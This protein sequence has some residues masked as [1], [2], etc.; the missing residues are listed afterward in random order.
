[1]MRSLPDPLMALLSIFAPRFSTPVW[2]HVQVLRAGAILCQGPHPVAAVL[3]VMGLEGKHAFCKYH[4]VLSRARWSGWHGSKILFGRLVVLVR[5]AGVPLRI[6]I[7]ETLDRRQGKRIKAKGK[8]RDA[9]RSTPRVVVK[10]GR[11]KWIC[12]MVGVPLPWRN[13]RWALPFLSLLAPSERANQPAGKP[14]KT[15][16]EWAIR[17]VRIV[18]RWL[19]H[20][21]WTLVGDGAYA[22]VA[23]AQACTAQRVTL[24]SRLR[25]G[26]RRLD[27]PA[28]QPAGNRGRKPQKGQRRR[29]LSALAQAPTSPWQETEMAWYRGEPRRQQWLSG[30][31][32]WHPNG[33]VPVPIRWVLVVDPAGHHPPEAFFSTAVTLAPERIVA[34]LVLPWNVE[35]TFEEVRR[36]L[37]GETQR[38]WSDLA[39]ARTTPMLMGLFSLVCLMALRLLQEGTLPLRQAAWDTQQEAAFSDV[40]AFVRR[41]IG[42]GK[43]LHNSV[44]GTDRLEW[45]RS[46]VDALLDQLAAAA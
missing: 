21:S 3:R 39:I 45:S 36:H 6:V 17:A 22:R 38:Q 10:C 32:L 44:P 26:A 18:S 20:A 28:G 41:A 40:L 2:S 43:Y 31:C 33:L 37:G 16:V 11:L 24:V 12:R 46:E 42:A 9:V 5:A 19:W 4:R 30:G 25:L 23:L 29:R 7:D 27:F 8:Y 15:T 1:M 35:V 14:H 34:I 13:R